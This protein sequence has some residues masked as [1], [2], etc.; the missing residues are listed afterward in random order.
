MGAE[1]LEPTPT[2]LPIP[3]AT[4][5]VQAASAPPQRVPA[6]QFDN[7]AILDLLRQYDWPLDQAIAVMMCESGGNPNAYN[8]SGATGLFQLHPHRP[9]NFDPATNVAGAYAKY[10]DGVRQ[11]NA[12]AH[13]NRFGGCGHF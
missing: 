9:E 8:A 13:W 3:E 10:L 12:W 4:V 7:D 1:P 11:G 2:P 6:T 5:A